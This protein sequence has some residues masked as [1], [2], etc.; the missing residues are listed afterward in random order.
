MQDWQCILIFELR[1]EVN[2]KNRTCIEIW[3]TIKVRYD[4]ISFLCPSLNLKLSG[5]YI[6]FF[7][8]TSQGQFIAQGKQKTKWRIKLSKK[9]KAMRSELEQRRRSIQCSF[10]YKNSKSDLT[11]LLFVPK[12]RNTTYQYRTIDQDQEQRKYVIPSHNSSGIMKGLCHSLHITHSN[13]ACMI[14]QSFSSSFDRVSLANQ[15]RQE[16]LSFSLHSI[17]Y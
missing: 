4:L 17:I 11:Y 1:R 9:T 6:S 15:R 8:K 14:K 12:K 13:N 16:T 3:S 10:I 2:G 7:W 5:T